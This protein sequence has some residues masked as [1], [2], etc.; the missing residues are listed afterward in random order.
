VGNITA[1]PLASL[2][3]SSGAFNTNSELPVRGLDIGSDIEPDIGLD[4]EPGM[5]SNVRL[6]IELEIGPD[7]ELDTGPGMAPP[8][9]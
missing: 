2:A 3:A 1:P 7:I 6:D 5:E 9:N 4:I 8:I